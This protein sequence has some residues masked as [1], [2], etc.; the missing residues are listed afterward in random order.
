[1]IVT[2][3]VFLTAT[4]VQKLYAELDKAKDLAL[5]RGSHRVHIRDRYAIKTLLESGLRVFEFVALKVG[6]FRRNVL[7]VQAGKFGKKR[8][9]VLTEYAQSLLREWIRAKKTYLGEPAG[10]ED[11][12]FL[13]QWQ[14]PYTTAGVR[15]RIKFW[16]RKCRFS[17]RFSCH[18]C[19]HTYVSHGLASGMELSRMKENVGHASLNTTS[20]YAHAVNNDLGSLEIY[21]R[22]SFASNGKRNFQPKLRRRDGV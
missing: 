15:K 22:K 13:S 16:F 2:Q 10:P 19:R 4:E 12:L 17:D 3:D 7:I 6:D 1:M 11:Y 9:V 5:F 20:I 21:Q 8:E 18:T 14:R